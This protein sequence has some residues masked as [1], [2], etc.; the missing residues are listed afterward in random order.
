MKLMV[1]SSCEVNGA[2]F[3]RI[4]VIKFIAINLP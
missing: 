3:T 2:N 1:E 4:F